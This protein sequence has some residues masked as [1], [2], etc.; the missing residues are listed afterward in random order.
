MT[1]AN[2]ITTG[3]T[4]SLKYQNSNVNLM[5]VDPRIIV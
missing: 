5:F 4:T 3:T 2:F 1:Q